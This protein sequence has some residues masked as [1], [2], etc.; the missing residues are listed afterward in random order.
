[1]PQNIALIVFELFIMLFSICLHACAQAA[2]LLAPRQHIDA[3]GTHGCEQRGQGVLRLYRHAAPLQYDRAETL[4]VERLHRVAIVVPAQR[5]LTHELLR[6]VAFQHPKL[7][8]RGGEDQAVA[9]LEA[10]VQRDQPWLAQ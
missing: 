9:C 2:C 3:F 6:V 4:F 5:A 7:Q 1:M 10:H 8:W